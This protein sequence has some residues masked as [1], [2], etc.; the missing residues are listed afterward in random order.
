M[1]SVG[2]WGLRMAALK[3]CISWWD[4]KKKREITA[5]HP[6]SVYKEE[7]F[8]QVSEDTSDVNFFQFVAVCTW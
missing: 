5:H 3:L 1:T 2:D 6:R 7:I 4:L 8:T